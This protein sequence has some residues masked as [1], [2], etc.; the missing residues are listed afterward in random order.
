MVTKKVPVK[1]R[2][3]FD[4]EKLTKEKVEHHGSDIF[5]NLPIIEEMKKAQ[6]SG[7][8]IPAAAP[9]VPEPAAEPEPEG[10]PEF[11]LS[12]DMLVRNNFPYTL[13]EGS[14]LQPDTL[15]NLCPLF[16]GMV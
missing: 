11:P 4:P 6:A 5:F 9:A 10:Q 16:I 8:F 2:K 15:P 7:A 12:P 13:V 1:C 14:G 3:D